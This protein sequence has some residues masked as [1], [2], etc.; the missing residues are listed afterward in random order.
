M[1]AALGE[2]P[3]REVPARDGMLTLAVTA[4]VLHEVLRRL[5]DAAGFESLT[6]VTAV[7][8]WPREPRFQVVHQ[9]RSLANA[10]RVRVETTLMD[11]DPRVPTCTDLWRGA[12][13]ME[14]ECW[15]MFGVR[16]EGH[17]D[18]RRLLMPEDYGHHP[19]RKEFPHHGIEPDRLY[20]EWD[21][22]RRQ[23]WRAE[24]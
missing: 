13:F 8:H 6:L 20:R 18:P 21:R 24:R 16:F 5:R 7:D 4:D 1:A 22:A 12:M 2:L 9:L 23:E 15:D 10:D 3:W 19:L 14:R 11:E 17:P